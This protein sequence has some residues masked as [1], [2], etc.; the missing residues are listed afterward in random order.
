M[1][2]PTITQNGALYAL[3]HDAGN[4][5]RERHRK[6]MLADKVIRIDRLRPEASA[7]RKMKRKEICYN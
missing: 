4:N 5:Y 7:V 3:Q 2:E 6:W 1:M